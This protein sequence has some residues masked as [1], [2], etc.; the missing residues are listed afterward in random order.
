L[1]EEGERSWAQNITQM[2]RAQ[3]AA[4]RRIELSREV[5][6]L[7][8]YLEQTPNAVTP[9]LVMGI[10]ATLKDTP[11]APSPPS[12]T[13]KRRQY[14]RYMN[15]AEEYE[16]LHIV[17]TNLLGARLKSEYQEILDD[18]GVREKEKSQLL[19]RFGVKSIDEILGLMPKRKISCENLRGE[20]RGRCYN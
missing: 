1:R 15:E 10:P 14:R 7:K 16:N 8:F 9:T 12:P 3:E 18:I 4:E 6:F 2:Q 20:Y 11:R 19:E 13:P 17:R 5:Y